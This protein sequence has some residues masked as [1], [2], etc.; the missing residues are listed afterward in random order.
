MGVVAPDVSEDS[1]D[2][3]KQR[4]VAH[5]PLADR[6]RP[7]TLAEVV[8]H[9][10]ILN[11]ASILYSIIEGGHLCS[12]ILWGPPGVGKT[13]LARLL[14][15]RHDA[16]LVELSAVR[17]G[18]PEL[19]KAAA[20][21][22]DWHQLHGRPTVLF[23]DEVHRFS[24]VQQDFL[25]PLVE[26]GQ[27]ILVAA[28]TEHPGFALSPALR[29]R[30]A[31]VE[32]QALEES[33]LEQ[34]M[35]RA[36]EVES[37]SITE[38]AKQQALRLGAGD[39]R[40]LL[41]LLERAGHLRGGTIDVQ[42]VTTAAGRQGGIYEAKGSAHYDTISAFIKAMR[43]SDPDAT[44]HYLAR[45]IEG[46]EDPLF[47]ARRL[48]IF[49]S[50]DVGNADPHGLVLANAAAQA[51]QQLGLPEGRFALIQ[52]SLYLSC[53]PKSDAGY[54]AY[55]LAKSD[56]MGRSWPPI[57]MDLLPAATPLHRD[58]GRGVDYKNPHRVQMNESLLPDVLQGRVYY[59][60]SG[61]GME[62]GRPPVGKARRQ[63]DAGAKEEP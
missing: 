47:I 15:H 13:T 18:I 51:V 11:N 22:A 7:Q 32:L 57:P 8:G 41:N 2:L 39:A 6:L 61:Q 3:F 46:G 42:E 26:S 25:L 28:T 56:L 60:P 24:K 10:D 34:L 23:L 29:S 33:D 43:A 9:Q 58:Q 45:L 59:E 5:R 30:C 17:V 48:V 50:E 63:A 16:H 52:A 1:M 36:L 20:D 54:R 44:L 21:A 55:E 38:E 62:R 49:A 40:R 12:L 14:A 19:R 35:H 37:W 53:G 31:L 4:A 27:L